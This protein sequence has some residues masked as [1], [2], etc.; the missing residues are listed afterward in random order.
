MTEAADHLTIAAYNMCVLL[1]RRLGQ[2]GKSELITLRSGLLTLPRR[3]S[4][5][6]KASPCSNSP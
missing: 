4:A 6:P 1:Q 2:L 5:F 3:S